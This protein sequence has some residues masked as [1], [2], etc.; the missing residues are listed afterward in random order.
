MSCGAKGGNVLDHYMQRHGAE[1]VDAARALGAWKEG[2]TPAKPRRPGTLS[3]RDGL[4]LLYADAMLM[5]VVGSDIGQNR[6]PSE[7]DLQAVARAARRVL[8]VYEGVNA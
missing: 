5:F 7:A 4:E 2:D 8:V 3:A 1:F 6:T